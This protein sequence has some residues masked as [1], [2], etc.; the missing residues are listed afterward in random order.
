MGWRHVN[1]RHEGGWYETADGTRKRA[2]EMR[3]VELRTLCRELGIEAAHDESKQSMLPKVL[4]HEQ[5][6]AERAQREQG[7]R[8]SAGVV[9]SPWHEEHISDREDSAA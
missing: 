1:G 9:N 6:E 3:R 5:D 7:R 4:R 8:E 2:G